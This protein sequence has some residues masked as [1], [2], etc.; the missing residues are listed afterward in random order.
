MPYLNDVSTSRRALLG[1]GLGIAGMSAIPGVQPAFA[2]TGPRDGSEAPTFN[3]ASLTAAI[4][5]MTA[6]D[7]K[8]YTVTRGLVPAKL[9]ET[10]LASG[11][12]TRVVDLPLY[13]QGSGEGGWAMTVSRGRIYI[14]MYPDAAV[15]C[16]DPA[17]GKVHLVGKCGAPGNTFVF[18]LATA[19]DG[20]VFASTYSDGGLWQIDP[21]TE[22]ISKLGSPVPNAQYGRFVAAQG[23]RWVYLGA[24]QPT[25][26]VRYDRSTGQFADITPPDVRPYGPFAVNDTHLFSGGSRLVRMSLDGTNPVWVWPSA[27]DRS[28]DALTVAPDGSVY[29]AGA[30][31]GNLY[32]W[33]PGERAVTLVSTPA[34]NADHRSMVLLDDHTIVGGVAWGAIFTHDI[35]SGRTELIDLVSA[36]FVAGAEAP[37][38]MA[39]DGDRLYVGGHW[40][41]QVHD[42]RTWDTYRIP[43]PG[44]LKTLNVVDGLIYSALYTSTDLVRIDPQAKTVTV[45]GKIGNGQQR[46]W[47][48]R[49]HAPTQQLVI[50]SGPGTGAL[51]GCLTLW[52][53]ATDELTFFPD[54]L[55]DQM[56]MSVWLDGDIAYLAGNVISG[57]NTPPRRSTASVA[58]FDVVRRKLLW[59]AEPVA[60]VQ[61]Y[62]SVAVLDGKLYASV[63]VP[64]GG[65]FVMDL[66]TRQVT[67]RGTLPSFGRLLSDRGRVYLPT[68]GGG[69][70]YRLGPGLKEPQH[71]WTALG[72]RWYTAAQLQPAQRNRR[73]YW[74]LRDFDI[75]LYDLSG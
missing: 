65:W 57:G 5:G 29:A 24:Y 18:S 66:A 25:T 20:M 49:Y 19:A 28:F 12:V 13:G 27:E 10:D 39:V 1:L 67:S 70:I 46:P 6:Y 50:G 62:Q 63:R 52:N 74:G 36:G 73:T 7:G 41:L 43:V 15:H 33:I 72:N 34:R 16:F 37:Q 23:D 47:D 69:D 45:C 56:I 22:I 30:G 55:P 8:A 44:E 9:V 54:L 17:T 38:S 59:L 32:R 31:T 14:G 35:P 53:V 11:R 40:G 21:D 2:A 71:L 60:E 75:A 68:V 42:T 4:V 61:S 48:A 3:P 51:K 58:A 64:G 26:L